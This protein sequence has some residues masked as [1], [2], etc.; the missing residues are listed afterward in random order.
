MG[1]P[2]KPLQSEPFPA[3]GGC[4]RTAPAAASRWRSPQ[5]LPVAPQLGSGSAPLR[6]SPDLTWLYFSGTSAAEESL[7]PWSGPTVQRLA[8]ISDSSYNGRKKKSAG[9][10]P[11]GGGICRAAKNRLPR[12]EMGREAKA[13]EKHGCPHAPRK[14]GGSHSHLEKIELRLERNLLCLFGKEQKCF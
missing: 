10:N 12:E 13:K 2:L 7:F 11:V 1:R 9:V 3:H 5:P 6:L 4:H 8:I 14:T